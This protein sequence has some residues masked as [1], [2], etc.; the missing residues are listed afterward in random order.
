MATATIYEQTAA[1]AEKLLAVV[2]VPLYDNSARI[3]SSDIACSLALEHWQSICALLRNGLLPSAVVVHRAQFEAILRSIWL[4]YAATD[5]AVAKV[6]SALSVESE[7]AAK[8]MPQTKEMM[9]Q[10]ATKAPPQ[11]YDALKRFKDNSWAA[12]NS[13]VHA[14]IH[15]IRRHG[16]GYPPSLLENV[17]RNANGLAVL[18]C[19]QAAVLSGQQSLQ[20]VV[21][22]V[23]S[24]YS[25]CIPPPV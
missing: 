10:L 24:E 9:E 8:N 16:E 25:A 4:L 2:A 19:M 20:A 22:R 7:H 21:L 17:L 15:P 23:A 3:T 5:T 6:G 12:L 14:G 1:F 13:Y 18:S 11:A